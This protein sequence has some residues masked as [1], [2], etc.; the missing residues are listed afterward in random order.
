M[1]D[2]LSIQHG[3]HRVQSCGLSVCLCLS[4]SVCLSVCVC[5]CLSVCV[6]VF[7]Y[8]CLS[9]CDTAWCTWSAVLWSVCLSVCLCL[10]MS[11]CLSVCVCLCLSVCLSVFVYVCLSLCDTAWCTWSA[12]LRCVL[13]AWGAVINVFRNTSQLSSLSDFSLRIVATESKLSTTFSQVASSSSSSSSQWL[14]VH[15]QI[16]TA[17]ITNVTAKIGVIKMH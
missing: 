17:V 7:V 11:V 8:V 6:S 1:C 5:L 16:R 4:M 15:L 2:C 12:V 13:V 14:S 3:V 10:S 9:L